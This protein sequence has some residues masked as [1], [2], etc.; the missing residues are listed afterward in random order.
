VEIAKIARD[1]ARRGASEIYIFFNN[2]YFANA[3]VNAKSLIKLLEK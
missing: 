2:D 3:C 1:L